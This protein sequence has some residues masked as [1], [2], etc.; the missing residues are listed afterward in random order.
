MSRTGRTEGR[1]GMALVEVLVAVVIFFAAFAALLRVY[2]LSL[3]AL[4]ASDT[5]VASTLAAQEQLEALALVATNAVGV[6]PDTG[7]EAIPGYVCLVDRHAT[8]GTGLILSEAELRA[9]RR[10][11]GAGAVVWTRMVPASP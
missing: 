8:V 5:T 1:K 10:D 7:N 3:S 4:D 9:G 6:G 11:R 2:A